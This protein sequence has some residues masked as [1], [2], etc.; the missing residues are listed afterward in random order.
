M[1]EREGL[2]DFAGKMQNLFGLREQ[3]RELVAFVSRATGCKHVCLLFLNIDGEDFTVLSYLPKS[4]ANPFRN[5]ELKRQDP[6]VKYLRQKKKLLTKASLATLP[7]FKRLRR[8]KTGTISLDKIALLVPVISR[9]QLIGVLILGEK[10][11]GGYAPEEY[12]LVQSVTDLVAVSMEKEYLREQLGQLK[13]ELSVINRSSAI[14]A[15]SLDIQRIFDSFIK[16]LSK[17]VD[18]DWAA[19]NLIADRELYILSLSSEIGSTWKVGERISMSGTAT[20]WVAQHKKA[21]VESD[22]TEKSLFVTAKSYIKQGVRSIAY[23]PLIAGGRAIGSLIIASRQSNAYSRRQMDFLEKLAAQITMPIEHSQLY[24]EVEA[25]SRIDGLT[26]LFNRRSFD[27]V[28]TN[29]SSRFSRYGGI[30]SLIIADLDN[31]KTV[32][33][34][35]GHLAGDEA[36]RQVGG[37]IRNMIRISDQAF[38]YGG[39]EFAI[40]LPNTSIDAA[41]RVAER[42]RQQVA[43][44]LIDNQTPITISLG[45]ACWPANGGDAN[46]IIAAA[47]AALYQA[48]RSGGN[49]SQCAANPLPLN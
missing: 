37:V 1:K 15:S 4:K 13:E 49:K 26:G 44:T 5:L 39:D 29:E 42:I 18:I 38:R 7:D 25:K 11:P 21:I 36:L 46:A 22:L 19:I 31:L 2:S 35:Y 27:E 28:M 30:F 43:S 24:A 45:L 14:M 23:L 16:E 34:A 41:N 40:F 20:E 3:G 17:I 47:D 6:I 32:N 33:D 9:D 48:K 12:N 10:S 8:Q